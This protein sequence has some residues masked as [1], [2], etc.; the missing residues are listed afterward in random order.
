MLSDFETPGKEIDPQEWFSTCEQYLNRSLNG[1]VRPIQVQK[2]ASSSRQAPWRLDVKREAQVHSYV[3]CLNVRQMEHEYHILQALQSI[4]IPTPRVFGWDPE[5][6]A[7]GVPAFLS[8]F[9]PGESLLPDMLAGRTWAEN[10]YLDTVTALQSLTR[11]DLSEAAA[12][13]SGSESAADVLEQAGKFLE[14]QSDSLLDSVY[15]ALQ[16]TMPDLPEVRF[17]R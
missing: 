12:F 1:K 4:P 11:Q 6:E 15:R 5:G 9:I 10:L 8:D 3:L 16:Q 17:S 14:P 13:I 2:L 7:F